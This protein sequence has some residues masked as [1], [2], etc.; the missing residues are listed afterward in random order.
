ML[1]K[2]RGE[3]STD[4]GTESQGKADGKAGNWRGSG[5]GRNWFLNK[6]PYDP[7]QD[8]QTPHAHDTTFNLLQKLPDSPHHVTEK[9][10][11]S[12]ASP[13]EF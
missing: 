5:R 1:G 7:N 11:T 8:P 4:V 6:T 3:N 10:S 12:S 9:C 13:A 2:H